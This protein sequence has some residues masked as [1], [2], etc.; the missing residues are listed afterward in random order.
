MGAFRLDFDEIVHLPFFSAKHLFSLRVNSV[1][2]GTDICWRNAY[3]G[4]LP[5][6]LVVTQRGLQRGYIVSEAVAAA[7]QPDPVIQQMQQRYVDLLSRQGI[8]WT[9][10]A[11][12]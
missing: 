8:R 7:S 11:V 5:G 10:G 9:S 1:R 4:R 6:L 3:S 2:T 12:F